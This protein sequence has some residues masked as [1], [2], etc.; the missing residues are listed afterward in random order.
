MPRQLDFENLRKC[1]DNYPAERLFI[2]DCGGVREDGSYRMHGKTKVNE[3]LEGRVLDFS[4]E[5]GLDFLI[6]GAKVW[7]FGLEGYDKGFSLA[8]ERIVDGKRYFASTGVDPDD[9]E[10]PEPR[11]S[12]LRHVWD[13]HLI[14]IYFKGRIPLKFYSWW[15][16]PHWKYWTVE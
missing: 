15:K 16:E 6:D 12:F 11:R 9:P 13:D 5:D 1:I 7:H 4:L 8:Y 14:E 3:E 2:R 10:L